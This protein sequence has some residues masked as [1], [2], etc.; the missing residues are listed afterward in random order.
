MSQTSAASVLS[1]IIRERRSVKPGFFKSGEFIP[2]NV[3]RTALENAGY[4]PNHGR[5]EPWHFI[6]F[7]GEGINRLSEF[8]AEAYKQHSGDKFTE[9]KYQNLKES[10]RKAS[11]VIAICCKREPVSRFP[12][13]EDTAAVACAVQNLALT[14]HAFGY[15][16][17]WT[18][19]GVTYYESA[20]HFFE[21]KE[22]DRLMGF[23]LCGVPAS[24]P[25]AVPRQPIEE[26]TTWI[27]G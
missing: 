5:T 4:A 6:V 19:G 22:H 12:E 17:Y 2:D 1:T 24:L 9:A 18:T 27:T 16:G 25:P 3:I 15:G 11:H 20:K 13:V 10:Y 26:K 8:Q 7:K 14:L 23:Y 21:L